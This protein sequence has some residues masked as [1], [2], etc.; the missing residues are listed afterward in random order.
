MLEDIKKELGINTD[1][2]R[3]YV[4][5][6]LRKHI[7]K[8]NHENVLKYYDDVRNIIANP[9]YIGINPNEKSVSFECI[10]VMEDNVLVAVKLDS[11]RSYFY[12]ASIYSITESKLKKMIKSG[13]VRSYKISDNLK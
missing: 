3:L 7:I 5:Q 4:S 11:K 8:H 6:G 1:I 10:K 12:V 9:D 2:D 13:R